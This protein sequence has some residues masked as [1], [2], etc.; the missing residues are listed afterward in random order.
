MSVSLVPVSDVGDTADDHTDDAPAVTA[1]TAVLAHH[2]MSTTIEMRPA[3]L[4]SPVTSAR[5]DSVWWEVESDS[6][7]SI[8]FCFSKATCSGR[9]HLESR[10]VGPTRIS[11]HSAEFGHGTKFPSRS[12]FLTM[13]SLPWRTRGHH[14]SVS[15]SSHLVTQRPSSFTQI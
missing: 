3:P 1:R 11:P 13:N 12:L 5:V 7:S 8:H 14:I 6:C 9:M 2:T 4:P 15:R 10:R